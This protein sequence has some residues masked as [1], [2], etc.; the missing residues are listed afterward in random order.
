MI[1]G[2][3]NSIEEVKER[4]SYINS[5]DEYYGVYSPNR[6]RIYKILQIDAE[7]MI[8]ENKGII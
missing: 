7:D 8:N 1:D 6:Y 4:L 3:C 5:Q 2:Y